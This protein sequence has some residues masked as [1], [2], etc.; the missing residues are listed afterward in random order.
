MFR[1]VL[2]LALLPVPGNPLKAR[3][4]GPYI[5]DQKVSELNYVALTRGRLKQKQMC[6]IN[7]LKEYVKRDAC[8]QV[9]VVG[10]VKE[11]CI[12]GI[13]IEKWSV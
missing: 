7:T 4:Y 3:H 12:V 2:I 11:D 10:D 1:S 6:H 13:G 9:S 5:V 8:K